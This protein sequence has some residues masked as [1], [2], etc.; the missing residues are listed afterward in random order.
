MDGMKRDLFRDEEGFTSVGV[1]LALLITLSLVFSAGQVYRLNAAA[2]KV[3][4]VADAAALA[5]Q[6]V[7]AEFM[8]VV[9]V[10]DAAVLSL[11]LTSL[12]ATGLGVAA[13]CTPVTAPA[14]EALL[15]A[16]RSVARARD[17][18]A[19][20]AASGLNRLQRA[21]PF[22]SAANAASV[23]TADGGG[24]SSYLALAV[25]APDEGQEIVVGADA[26]TEALQDEVDGEAEGISEAA[27]RAEEAAE[28]ANEAKLR[29]FERD[30][31][32]NPSYCMYERARSLAGMEGADNPLY[33]SVDTWSF[34]VA[35]ERAK[36]YYP[37]RLAAERSENDS[38][39]ER[40]RSKLRE[41][42]YAYAAQEVERGYV[43][44]SEGSFEAFFPHLPKNTEEMRAT[45]LYTEAVYPVTEGADGTVMHAWE[46]CPEAAGAVRFGSIEQ[47]EAGSY[48]TCPACGFSAASM[49]KVAAASTSIDNGFEYHY[50]KV[51]EAAEDY[52]R[53]RA[54]LD[55]LANEVR[56]RA[57]GLFD[58]L[59][60]ALGSVAGMRIDARPPGAL[61]VVVLAAC[62]GASESAWP[63]PFV[64]P[65]GAL[66][67]QAAVSAA[68]LVADPAGEGASVV[69]SLLDGL[70]D[71]GGAAVGALGIVL[72]CWSGVLGAYAEGQKALDGAVSSALDGLPLA[73]ASGLGSWAAGALS[74]VV[75]AVGLEP[76]NLDALKPAL[77]NSA[78]VAS[79]DD[80]AFAAQLLSLKR[81]A[82]ESPFASNDVF[83]SIVGLV[84]GGL[85]EG[86]DAASGSIV[87]A[88]VRV[89]GDSGPAVP[90]EFALP[91]AAKG[92]AVD[93][94]ERIADGL[95]PVCAQ[96]TGA[97]V[98]E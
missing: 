2:S 78:H 19:E 47:M 14:S 16:G 91:E 72:D 31:G 92:M 74:E 96:V 32:A 82:M 62:T 56:E 77:V 40:A 4:N 44:E 58:R 28:R 9:K 64:Q 70:R 48:I 79:A 35:L 65:A 29:G 22:L 37:H 55:P 81:G 94:I 27:K 83:Q 17:S 26:A 5:A 49:G 38:V 13:L 36:A 11:S 42:F 10:C 90:I 63:G 97:R 3:Q 76:A 67:A 71:D 69:S 43:R 75:S 1:V 68:T 34:A 12:A 50:E 88:E 66:G 6:N 18:F 61:G 73:G 85:V 8:I 84:E 57:G 46:G 45:G 89:F 51:A 54:E 23:A 53:A 60:D 98:W 20:K 15:S 39:E 7:V 21:L 86:I 24:S 59:G 41:R 87:I 95:R 25:L 80:G 30:C 33:R 52:E 93:V